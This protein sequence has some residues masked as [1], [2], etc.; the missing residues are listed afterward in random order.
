MSLRESRR[1]DE[2]NVIGIMLDSFRKDHLGCYGN[3]WIKTPNL[4]RFAADATVFNHAY[5]EGLP[6]LPVRTALFTGR[7]TLPF[8][9]W[10]PLELNDV[11]LAEILWS[12]GVATAFISDT[13]HAHK[14][15][16]AYERGFDYV[17]WVRGQENDPDVLD[18]NVKVDLSKWSER[19]WDSTL[20]TEE[21]QKKSMTQYLQNRAHW[22]TDED[23]HVAQVMK[24]GM[25]WL[26]DTVSEGRKK[27]FFLWLDS[28]DPHEPWDPP[29][30][31]TDM[32]PVPDYHGLPIIARGGFVDDW[33]L[34]EIRHI[35]S[36]YA[37]TI[38]L[39]DKWTGLF[40]EKIKELG[41]LGNTMII[42]IA[43]HGEPLGEHGIVSK[44]YP[45]CYDELSRVPLFIR[46]PDGMKAKRRVDDFANMPDIAPTILSFLGVETPSVMNGKNLL[47]VM[48]G[49]EKGMDFAISGFHVGK[50]SIRNH[51]WSCH[52]VSDI[53][54]PGMPKREMP[55]IKPELYL[56][57]PN[58]VPPEPKKYELEKDQ[59][60]TKDI[61][62]EHEEIGEALEKQL[63]EFIGSL[64]PS[65]GDISAQRFAEDHEQYVY[66]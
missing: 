25:R 19:N 24:A 27:S 29:T 32:Y 7:Y 51:K 57:D 28:F 17:K 46:L 48:R 38:T 55:K 50:W 60:E 40:L 63:R 23:H 43:D 26:E 18:P 45:W 10:Q 52:K 5:A 2:L 30:Q 49:E 62:N 65:P 3:K 8:R 64:K 9:F 58:Y 66:V 59:A 14:P 47:P 31:F 39:V 20:G 12:K 42:I 37:G 61:I 54:W 44:C 22:K 34:P 35:R 1:K 4:D 11:L 16:M 56:Y 33:T 41:L 13:Y 6:T 53:E 21:S 36:Q 15:H